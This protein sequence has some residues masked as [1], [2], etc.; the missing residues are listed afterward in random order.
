MITFE[1]YNLL[2]VYFY[3][4]YLFNIL[5]A[6]KCLGLKYSSAKTITSSGFSLYPANI[7]FDENYTQDKITVI[8]NE[9]E[10]KISVKSLFEISMSELWNKIDE[11]V[12]NDEEIH[13]K[14]SDYYPEAFGI[15]KPLA[16]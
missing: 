10:K 12:D 4:N 8:E 13:S 15:K 1:N 2:N 9:V 5:K 16:E 14:D 7:E 11:F 3:I 6:S